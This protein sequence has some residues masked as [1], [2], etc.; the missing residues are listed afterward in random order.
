[1]EIRLFTGDTLDTMEWLK[2]NKEMALKAY[3][4]P[5]YNRHGMRVATLSLEMRNA[6]LEEWYGR[7]KVDAFEYKGM[8]RKGGAFGS[9]LFEIDGNIYLYTD[10]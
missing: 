4:T 6:T 8:R 5:V 3:F 7:E 10:K 2:E 9:W 1:M